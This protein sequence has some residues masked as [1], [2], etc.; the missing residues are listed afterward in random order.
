MSLHPWRGSTLAFCLIAATGLAA[1][2]AV[3]D[4]DSSSS[5]A[6]R[7][8]TFKLGET[9][10]VAAKDDPIETVN[11][12][13]D[14]QKIED[15]NRDSVA[16]ALDLLPGVN[17]TTAGA[18]NEQTVLVR[19][20]D[21]RQVPVFL[22]GVPV[23]VPYDGDV[24]YARFTTFDLAEIQV[25][26][27]F[28][29]VAFGPNTLGGVIN[30]VTRRPTELV[31]GD[32]R[33]GVFDGDG[34]KAALNFGTNQGPWYLQVGASQVQANSFRLSGDFVPNS[35]EDGGARNNSD[36][37]DRKVSI[38]VGVTPDEKDEYAFGFTRQVGEKGVPTSVDFRTTARYWRWPEWDKNSLYL[39]TH[40]TLGESS[41]V[42]VRAYYDTY[43]NTLFNYTDA[44]YT[45]L[46]HNASWPTGKSIYDDFTHGVML[47]AGTEA[48][49]R[50][51]LKAVL[52]TKTDVHREGTGAIP[53]TA[54]WLN[55]EDRFLSAGLEDSITLSESV[56]LSL[57]GGWDRLEPI[58]SGPTW[59]LPDTQSLWH[60]QAGVFWKA[61]PGLKLYATVAQK[62]RFP[63]LKDRYSSKFATH[64]P[65]PGLKAEQSTNYEAG[66][67]AR[68]GEWLE[69]EA[70]LFLS[71]IRDLIQDVDTGTPLPPPQTGHWMQQQ[72]IGKVRHSGVELALGLKPAAWFQGGLGYTYLDRDN[73][74]NPS[75]PLLYTP[76]NRVT[77]Y[78]KVLPA[79]NVFAMVDVKAQD[80]QWDNAVTTTTRLG[81][82]TTVGLTLG[83]EPTPGFKLDG[84]F[85]NLLDRN[86][87]LS[88][89]YPM[90]GRTAFANARY[91]F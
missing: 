15:F 82:F 80:A 13:V 23:Y 30:L 43:K 22:D 72:N 52:Q 3:I 1:A 59:A 64:I 32:L 77:G 76:R 37:Q 55:Y 85:T 18:R 12:R 10:V 74:S 36:F 88:T 83:W 31:E 67:K 5:A 54:A 71:D 65:N 8:R 6:S 53:D 75:Q 4:P 41:H 33:L 51:S 39:I 49:A 16:T 91:R 61:G 2:D 35:R 58:H 11:T 19:G 70:A 27:G 87:A 84:G 14:A 73:R 47:E 66:M 48:F 42:G 79:P 81:G 38:K 20:N 68:R 60:G 62:D 28:S 50:H 24:D 21:S 29:S 34:R 17:Y 25:E 40:T 90:P 63:T 86:Y 56:D 26:K 45:T 44:T 46:V 78:A 89:G 9:V 69:A 7:D 57:G